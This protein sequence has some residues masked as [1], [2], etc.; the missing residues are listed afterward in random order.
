[1]T[2]SLEKEVQDRMR[3]RLSPL[4]LYLMDML[5]SF[6]IGMA[7]TI[8]AQAG[9]RLSQRVQSSETVRPAYAEE[10]A[11]VACCFRSEHRI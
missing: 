5:G 7:L 4:M 8:L 10:S 1:M 6:M 2:I 11:V 3:V 9:W